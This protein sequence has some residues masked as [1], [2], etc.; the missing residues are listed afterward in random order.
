MEYGI[1]QLRSGIVMIVLEYARS[2]PVEP[3]Q[4]TSKGGIV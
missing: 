4:A 1:V 3:F 2:T